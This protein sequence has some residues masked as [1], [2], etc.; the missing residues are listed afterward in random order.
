M[1]IFPKTPYLIIIMGHIYTIQEQEKNRFF[2]THE[3]CRNEV[4]SFVETRIF[5]LSDK[6]IWRVEG[7]SEINEM[8]MLEIFQAIESGIE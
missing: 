7:E 5:V 1:E 3:I 6:K 8:H 2:V 4:S